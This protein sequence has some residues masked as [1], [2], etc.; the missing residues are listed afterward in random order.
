ML[1][2]NYRFEDAIS[3]FFGV[4]H[5]NLM[6]GLSYDI[7]TSDLGKMVNGS[8]GFEISLS[9]IGRKSVKTPEVEFV[10]PRL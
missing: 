2:A 9:F 5:K 6:I 1:G 7:N 10:C 8:N 4:T 3:P